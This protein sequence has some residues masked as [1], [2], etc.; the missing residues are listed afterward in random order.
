MQVDLPEIILAVV[1]MA[2]GTAVQASLGFGLAMI[3]A[4]LLLLLNPVF[5]PG[6]LLAAA[7]MLTVWVAWKERHAIVPG[8]LK[9]TICGRL[10]GTVPAVLLLGT[11]SAVTFDIIF[12]VLVVLAVA[13]SIWHSALQPTPRVI[14]VA[15]IAA[16][17]MGTISSI[18]GP[19]VA[20]A[21]QNANGANLRANLSLLFAIGAGISLCALIVIG[22]FGFEELQLA[23]LLMM[24]VVIGVLCSGP[25]RLMVDKG[26]ARPYLLGLCLISA[27]GVL[28]RALMLLQ[29]SA[30]Q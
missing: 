9:A 18:G 16:G 10:L 7:L 6:P 17:F 15:S 21:Y 19:P 22:R 2:A 5:V 4:P 27:C 24:G 3:A 20:L 29:D 1:V 14:F 26:T 8:Y 28:L 11:I 30:A 25:V 13:L 12:A 23:A